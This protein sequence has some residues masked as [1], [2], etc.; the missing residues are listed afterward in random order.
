[1][2][3]LKK[4]ISAIVLST[5]FASMQISYAEYVNFDT[6][7]GKD[8]TGGAVIN[9]ATSG[10]VDIT[11]GTGTADLNFNANTHVNWDSLNVN[12]GETLN[13]NAVDGANNLTILNT[14]NRG[15]SNIY[16]QVNA[17]SGIGKLII[18][19][20]N[21]MLFDGAKFTTAG[22][23]M[24]TT[25]DMSGLNVNDLTEAKFVQLYNEGK[26]IPININNSTFNVAGDYSIVAAGINAANSTITANNLKLITANGQDFI[27]L[28]ET[29]PLK[30]QTVTR[31]K[32]MNINGNVY[33]TNDIGA[34]EL[35]EG[36]SIS[37]NLKVVTNGDVVLNYT[38]ADQ[39]LI[40]NGNA[41]IKGN[42][43]QMFLRNSDVN[44]N[45][46]MHNGGGFVDIG[47]VH[48]TKDAALTTSN[49]S[50]NNLNCKPVRHFVHVIG[51]TK[52]DGDLTIEAQDNIHIGGYNYDEKK[53][54]DGSLTV[55]GNLSAHSQNG[56]VMTIINTTAD[57]ISLKSDKLNVLTDG[58]ALLTAKEYEFS[59]NG[60]IGGIVD[61]KDMT[62]EERIVS[63]MENYIPVPE[64][65]T[66]AYINIA[67]GNLTKVE[68]PKT[69]SA[70]ISS[71]GNLKVTG[72]N[73]GDL[74]ITAPGKYIEITGDGVHANNV[75]VGKETDKL[76]VDFESRDY[77][78][79][80]TNIKNAEQVVIKGNDKVTYDLTNGE[81]GYNI[82]AS[83]PENT[84]Y[85]VGPDKDPVNPPV[86]P[87]NPPEDPKPPINP[88]DND[89]VKI[90]NNMDRDLVAKSIDANPV[91]TPVA[92]AA[93]LDDDQV[94]TGVRKNVDGSVTV[95]RAF[96]MIN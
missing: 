61:T 74:N 96:P 64:V 57:K 59:S 5:L 22:D 12:R 40:I 17:N 62:K 51:D 70:Y 43:A 49:L 21:G 52:V 95:V 55:G 81:E 2:R 14:V 76:K 4:K 23:L 36:G 39:K 30:N 41:D 82:R 32:A 20:P 34:L 37:G 10:L 77:D 42:G 45:L 91:N 48:V 58:K 9:N 11:K 7:L 73:T 38:N 13:F 66:P 79:K 15:M 90:L 78:L 94:D 50:T 54:A 67:G 26:L 25:Q 80:Y 71:Q 6:G 19:N 35:L 72:A 27:A 69:S 83:R 85:L 28:G 56:H 33:I 18:S 24:I 31:L 46:T 1:M 53:L 65:K 88:S 84:T 60:Y 8:F 44:G 92:Y 63:I 68:T 29:L 89:N 47:D 75:I 87:V 3:N 16:G 86:D 93:D